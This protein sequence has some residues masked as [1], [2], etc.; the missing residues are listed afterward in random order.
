[1][2]VCPAFNFEVLKEVDSR[3]LGMVDTGRGLLVGS[4][5]GGFGLMVSSGLYPAGR[6]DSDL[7]LGWGLGASMGFIVGFFST[8]KGFGVSL[9]FGLGTGLLGSGL[10][11]W[12]WFMVE[13]SRRFLLLES[14]RG[15]R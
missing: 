13:I 11:I 6:V 8:A 9:G 5:C 15:L 3:R 12:D 10:M 4:S 2:V 1:M 14:V 7:V